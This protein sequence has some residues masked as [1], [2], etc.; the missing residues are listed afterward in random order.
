MPVSSVNRASALSRMAFSAASPQLEK[1][2]VMSSSANA[3][4][5]I[6]I[7]D[8]VSNT[9]SSFFMVYA[10]FHLLMPVSGFLIESCP[11]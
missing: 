5:S 3:G 11:I 7:S 9:H 10:S 8:R 2:S 1:V 6:S 4:T